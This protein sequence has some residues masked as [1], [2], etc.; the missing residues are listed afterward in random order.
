MAGHVDRGAKA[1]AVEQAG[2]PRAFRGRQ[3]GVGD[4]ETSVVELGVQLR[5]GQPAHPV[6]ERRVDGGISHVYK[7]P[8]AIGP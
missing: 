7:T 6:R 4:R 2:Q 1:P 8:G 3:N 5:P